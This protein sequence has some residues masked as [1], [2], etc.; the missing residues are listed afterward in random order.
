MPIHHVPRRELHDALH[1]FTR[2]SVERVT[3]VIPDPEDSQCFLV[4]TE[5]VEVETRPSREMQAH[6]AYAKSPDPDWD[7]RRAMYEQTPEFQKRSEAG[8]KAWAT[9]KANLADRA[10]HEARHADRVTY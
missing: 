3:S 9:R 7:T 8:R 2:E 6:N 4:L 10:E 5:L 1:R